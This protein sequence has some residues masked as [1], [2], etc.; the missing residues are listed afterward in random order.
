MRNKKTYQ[1]PWRYN[2]KL[3]ILID[4]ADYFSSML[5][6]IKNSQNR[7]LL[8]AYLFE[9]G[10]IADIFIKELCAA[11]KRNVE[12]YILLDEYGT[13]G[14]NREDKEKI[15]AAGIKLLL[16]NPVNFFHF[17]RRT[18]TS[19]PCATYLLLFPPHQSYLLLASLL[20]VQTSW[21]FSFFVFLVL[22]A[23]TNT[24]LMPNAQHPNYQ[25][26]NNYPYHKYLKDYG[27]RK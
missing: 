10:K 2:N 3:Q 7:I 21:F 6:E 26:V 24:I 18:K 27:Y 5:H 20:S 1:Y 22:Y 12:I 16:Y 11:K 25:H 9:S 4:G 23:Q 17:G 8:E 19:L 13:K 14:L 15:I